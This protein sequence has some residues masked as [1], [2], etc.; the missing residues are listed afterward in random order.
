MKGQ[1][2][3]HSPFLR[4][5]RTTSFWRRLVLAV[6]LLCCGFAPM[7]QANPF[8]SSG[9]SETNEGPL[10]RPPCQY[11]AFYRHSAGPAGTA[12]PISGILSRTSTIV[13]GFCCSGCG[14]CL[15]GTACGRAWASK[16]H[17]VFTLSGK[18]L[19]NMGSFDGR[20]FLSLC[21]CRFWHYPDPWTFSD[22]GHN[23]RPGDFR[24]YPGI[25]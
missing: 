25:P 24:A 20:F 17:C 14:F 11:G 18:N 4:I 16:D 5:H 15:W 8:L 21:S 3:L 23:H 1:H 19:Q 10:V 12:G 7:V 9:S 22:S 2:S 13:S 6:F